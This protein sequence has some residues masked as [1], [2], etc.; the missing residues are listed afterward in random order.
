MPL[1]LAVVVQGVRLAAACE[2]TGGNFGHRADQ[3]VCCQV[4]R[5]G[6]GF[7]SPSPFARTD[8]PL[9]VAF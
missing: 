3:E 8:A 1:A 5:V 2:Q 4:S 6:S 7:A 9:N